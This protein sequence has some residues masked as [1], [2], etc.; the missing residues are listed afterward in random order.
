MLKKI[1]VVLTLALVLSS[2]GLMS[3]YENS[4]DESLLDFESQLSLPSE[5]EE[6][7]VITT[8]V[9][10]IK[11]K[12][13]KTHAPNACENFITLAKEGYYN[14]SYVFFI[15]PNVAFMA[16]TADRDGQTATTI[17]ENG[18]TF[19]NET[20]DALWHFSGAVSS[21]SSVKG[22]ND[23]RFFITAYTDVSEEMLDSMQ[24]V[25]YPQSLIDKYSEVGGAPGLDKNYT[26]FA[27]V[28]DSTVTVEKIMSA[29]IDENN[30]PNPEIKIEKIEIVKLKYDGE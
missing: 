1:I 3:G 9:G 28:F 24:R 7:A 30:S 18:K 14:G 8:N 4:I 2:C 10:T 29:P 13:F 20:T 23:S 22:K 5:D 16:G 11:M 25:G 12:F 26:V 15:E 17:F 6:I 19:E 27:Q 21:M